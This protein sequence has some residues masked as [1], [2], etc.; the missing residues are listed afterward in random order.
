MLVMEE[1][2]SKSHFAKNRKAHSILEGVGMHR[3]YKLCIIGSLVC[4]SFWVSPSEVDM[5]AMEKALA[6]SG[7][8]NITTAA[9]SRKVND[10]TMCA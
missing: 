4:D 3:V 1:L 10:A 8:A 7:G 2:N 5:A 9:R 6:N